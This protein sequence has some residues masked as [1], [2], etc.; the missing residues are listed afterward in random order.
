MN[1]GN[2]VVSSLSPLYV[3][4]I[5]KRER[6]LK[7]KYHFEIFLKYTGC[8]SRN[9][10]DKFREMIPWVISRRK[11]YIYQCPKLNCCYIEC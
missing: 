3:G 1:T 6:K 8:F 10:G 9:M 11:V 7:K 4:K 2:P 5:Q